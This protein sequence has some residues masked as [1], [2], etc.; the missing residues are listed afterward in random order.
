MGIS[1]LEEVEQIRARV[2]RH[3]SDPWSRKL[4]RMRGR[5][6]DDGIERLSTQAIFDLLEV[7]QRC[8]GSGAGRRLAKLMVA[9]GWSPIRVRGLSRGTH[10]EQIRGYTRLREM[11]PSARQG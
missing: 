9:A 11:S 3:D 2:E 4:E 8:R 5:T 1:L 7:P 6:G 10:R